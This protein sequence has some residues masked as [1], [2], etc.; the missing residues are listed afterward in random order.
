MTFPIFFLRNASG[1]VTGSLL[2]DVQRGRKQEE[3]AG[4]GNGQSAIPNR[5][6][7]SFIISFQLL[8]HGERSRV[9]YLCYDYDSDLSALFTLI[10]REML[11]SPT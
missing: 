3:W 6:L 9:E 1:S 11:A 7:I 10:S 4:Y 2:D 8:F 5:Y